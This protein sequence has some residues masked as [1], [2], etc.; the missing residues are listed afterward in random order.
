MNEYL[1][2]GDIKFIPEDNA[3]CGYMSMS[4]WQKYHKSYNPYLV[5]DY[6]HSDNMI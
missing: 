1:K 4:V 2:E 3:V 6:R 5:F